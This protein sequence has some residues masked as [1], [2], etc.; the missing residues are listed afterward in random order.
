MTSQLSALAGGLSFK[1]AKSYY[2]GWFHKG[3]VLGVFHRDSSIHLPM[4]NF[5]ATKSFSKVVRHALCRAPNFMKSTP[6]L[7]LEDSTY[8]FSNYISV[9]IFGY[10]CSLVLVLTQLI[11]LL[12]NVRWSLDL[13]RHTN[14]TRLKCRKYDNS[15]RSGSRFTNLKTL[16]S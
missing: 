6:D 16:L 14:R 15:Y 11:I 4:P 1:K 3:S 10:I 13:C 9:I 12:C 5:Y 8:S 2:W 7:D